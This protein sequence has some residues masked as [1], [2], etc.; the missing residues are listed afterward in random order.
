MRYARWVFIAVLV[1][2]TACGGGGDDEGNGGGTGTGTATDTVTM[3]DNAFEPTDPVVDAGSTL[4]LVN[5][6]AATHT[7]TVADES[8]DELV[9]T[10]AE[11]SVDITLAAGTY[12][13]DCSLH[14]EMSG[15]LTVQ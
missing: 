7:F 15:T 12:D 6:G 11:S 14:P 5:E 10:G 2:G 3:V 13:F 1:A 4:S 9:E 8:I